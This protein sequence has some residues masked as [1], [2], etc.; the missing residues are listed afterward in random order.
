M[1]TV[2]PFL[3]AL[4]EFVGAR[5]DLD[6]LDALN[7]FIRLNPGISAGTL[8]RERFNAALQKL[9][10]QSHVRLP[11]QSSGWD[12]SVRPSLPRWVRLTREQKGTAAFDHKTYPW[13]AELQW[14][15]N[16]TDISNPSTWLSLN[17]FFRHDGASC[18]LVPVKERS[19]QIFGDEKQLERVLRIRAAVAAGMTAASFRCFHVSHVPVHRTFPDCPTSAI[20]ISENEAGFDSHCRV[21]RVR[22]R[23]RTIIYG[24][25]E[26]VLKSAEFISQVALEG[27][28]AAVE[29]IGDID[30]NGLSMPQRLNAR[31]AQSHRTVHVVPLVFAYE[32][33]LK[34]VVFPPGEPAPVSGAL[35]AWLP[36]PLASKAEL[37]LKRR[38]RRA[39][40]LVGWD[41]LATHESISPHSI[42]TGKPSDEPGD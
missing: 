25:G 13:E 18:P 32:H 42:N 31:L 14:L 11:V 3:V 24:K 33:L 38:E 22:P 19:C 1:D 36:E 29:Y 34:D 15:A 40:E 10:A 6:G 12:S 20:L 5:T 2:D 37:L 30:Q 21:N 8:Q 35:V 39:Q 28:V 7:V 16:Q 4:R 9:V 27:N 41:F 26:E 17:E 23:Y